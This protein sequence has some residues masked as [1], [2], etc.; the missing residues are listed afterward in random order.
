MGKTVQG[1]ENHEGILNAEII[2]PK[3]DF[4]R[5]RLGIIFCWPPNRAARNITTMKP[6][7][8]RGG[9]KPMTLKRLQDQF[10][11]ILYK[12]VGKRVIQCKSFGEWCEYWENARKMFG[13]RVAFDKI[14]RVEISTVFLS[15]DHGWGKRPVLFETRIFGGKLAGKTARYHTWTEAERGH[16]EMVKLVKADRRKLLRRGLHRP[17]RT[18]R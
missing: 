15:I 14:R 8:K 6:H 3:T 11:P 1:S 9:R 2:A 7:K 5:V 17:S 12:L 4:G 16:R 13:R 10:N 18:R